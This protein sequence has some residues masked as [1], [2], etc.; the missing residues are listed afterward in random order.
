MSLKSSLPTS[1]L[2]ALKDQMSSNVKDQL[3]SLK[4][5]ILSPNSSKEQAENSISLSSL[6]EHIANTTNPADILSSITDGLDKEQESRDNIRATLTSQFMS[7]CKE[8][9]AKSKANIADYVASLSSHD[10]DSVVSLVAR[11]EVQALIP[12][13]VTNPI[14]D[15]AKSGIDGLSPNDIKT[16]LSEQTGLGEAGTTAESPSTGFSALGLLNKVNEMLGGDKC[17]LAASLLPN[18]T[19][20]GEKSWKDTIIDKVA[21]AGNEQK[22]WKDTLKDAVL[23]TDKGETPNWKNVLFGENNESKNIKSAILGSL[24]SG[25]MS[26]LAPAL[27]FSA[28]DSPADGSESGFSISKIGKKAFETLMAFDPEGT[29]DTTIHNASQKSV[30][31]L[32]KAFELG[33]FASGVLGDVSD[34]ASAITGNIVHNKLEPYYDAI[35]DTKI[36]AINAGININMAREAA[37]AGDI[38][39]VKNCLEDVKDV[40]KK[41][42]QDIVS[43]ATLNVRSCN[44]SRN[45]CNSLCNKYN[46]N[47]K[48]TQQ[49]VRFC[50]G[51]C[52]NSKT[53]RVLSNKILYVSN[54]SNQAVNGRYR[55]RGGSGYTRI[56]EH[57][58]NNKIKIRYVST[59]GD[60][61]PN[62][63]WEISNYVSPTNATVLYRCK[64]QS[65]DPWLSWGIAEEDVGY[66]VV[67]TSPA[68][69]LLESVVDTTAIKDIQA[70]TLPYVKSMLGETTVNKL[71]IIN[72]IGTDRPIVPFNYTIYQA[73]TSCS[74]CGPRNNALAAAIKE[75]KL[76][77]H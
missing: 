60:Y 68:K 65:S 50:N 51:G 71:T 61:D 63:F 57:I 32:T 1:S 18:A 59:T 38:E 31:F 34:I 11:P 56:W 66:P 37:Y 10:T 15:I 72:A 55:L 28:P 54:A 33:P 39:T 67:S 43:V 12:E 6:V 29:V 75:A 3:A 44:K 45:T 17:D 76:A 5:S 24:S 46:V 22:S 25:L 36:N 16:T 42:I 30:G 2:S 41:T 62:V 9:A 35:A 4:E 14:A 58:N 13:S 47:S 52:S 7:N 48:E 49:P 64:H 70:V 19:P 69:P 73:H 26:E 20:G 23:G 27:P 53:N 40:S 21:N 77:Y 74:I 8:L